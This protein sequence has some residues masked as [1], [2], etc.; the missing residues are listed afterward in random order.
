MF[1]PIAIINLSN[2]KNNIQYLKSILGK[3]EI[4]PVVKADAYGHGCSM[5][6]KALNEESVNTVC[7]ATSDEIL[8]ILDMNIDMNILH[9]GKIFLNNDLLDD[10]VIFTIN[11]VEDIKYIE[12]FCSNSNGKVRCHIKV[13]TGMGRMGC[14]MDDFEEILTKVNSSNFIK[15]EAIYSHLACSEDKLSEHN[16]KQILNFNSLMEI[17]KHFGLSYHLLNS[18]GVFNYPDCFFDYARIGLATYGIS[19]IGN[20]DDKLKPV[21]MLKAPIVLVKDIDKGETVGYGCTFTAKEK[22][23]IALV[24]CGYADGIPRNFG[25]KGFVYF[26]DYE[27]PVIG[28]VSMDLMCID[29]SGFDRSINIDEV[30][31]WGGNQYNSRLENISVKFNSIPYTYLTG[32]SNRVRKIYVED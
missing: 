18:G 29:I 26:N 17:A 7:V 21:M 27:I 32:V 31:I 16:Q 10:R 6:I 3:S 24:Q 15:L 22:M 8:E 20:I 2:F 25:N 14:K 9:L 30:V 4:F 11:T 19:P 23:R 12:D 5:I 28:R 1:H 13:D